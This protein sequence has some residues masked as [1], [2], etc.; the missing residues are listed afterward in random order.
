MTHHRSLPY[1]DTLLPGLVRSE[2]S[3]GRPASSPVPAARLDGPGPATVPSRR[4]IT[5]V[6]HL[7]TSR[8]APGRQAARPEGVNPPK[9]VCTGLMGAVL[10]SRRGRGPPPSPH[11]VDLP[12]V[13]VLG[14]QGSDPPSTC[15]RG[16][17]CVFPRAARRRD[18]EFLRDPGP[19]V[20]I[21]PYR[22]RWYREPA[23]RRG[24]GDRRR[25]LACLPE[26]LLDA[27][28]ERHPSIEVAA[29]RKNSYLFDGE[30]RLRYMDRRHK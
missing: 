15:F 30:R 22:S 12:P 3:C 25:L 5:K 6:V 11:A 21:A 14:G 10:S 20:Y 2:A 23:P 19:P 28:T 1:S 18:R 7:R 16:S 27:I 26:R 4:L 8:Q 29:L 13:P 9:P 24:S 17:S